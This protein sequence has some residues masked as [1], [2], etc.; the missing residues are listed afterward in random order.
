LS[1]KFFRFRCRYTTYTAAPAP[2]LAKL[3]KS[4]FEGWL[5]NRLFGLQP[6]KRVYTLPIVGDLRET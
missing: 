6:S 4:W 2:V 1:N 5:L 3:G